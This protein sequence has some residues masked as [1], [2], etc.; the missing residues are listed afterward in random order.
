MIYFGLSEND[1]EKIEHIAILHEHETEDDYLSSDNYTIIYSVNEF[2][3]VN[4]LTDFELDDIDITI[5]SKKKAFEF[6]FSKHI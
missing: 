6:L 3:L 5:E 4:W 2:K 1:N